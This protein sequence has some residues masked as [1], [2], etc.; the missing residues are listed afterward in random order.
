MARI[1]VEDSIWSDSRFMQLCLLLGD[2]FKAVGCLVVAWKTAQQHWCPNRNPIPKKAFLEAGLPI[3]LV[4]ANFADVVEGEAILM[5]GCDKHFAWWFEKQEAGRKSAEARKEKYGSAQ[6]VRTPVR[7]SRTPVRETSNT[8]RTAPEPLTLTLSLDTINKP[9]TGGAPLPSVAEC[10]GLE[11]DKKAQFD[12]EKIFEAYPRPLGKKDG[13]VIAKR[14]I[15]TQ[16]NYE[17][18]ATAVNN[19]A[20]HMKREG[21]ELKHIKYFSSFM[22]SWEDWVTPPKQL[23][24]SLSPTVI[25]YQVDERTGKII[26]ASSLGS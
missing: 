10:V 26:W 25:D 12:F 11:S 23:R 2:Q 6:P 5:R 18:L 13:L 4:K 14:S 22:T 9:Q 8:T 1:N 16:E 3:E 20:E 21:T 19:Y 17:K 7:D 24:T 15:T